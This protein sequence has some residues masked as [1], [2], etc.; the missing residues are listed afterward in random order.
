MKALVDEGYKVTTGVLNELDTDYETAELLD[1]PTVSESPF[2]PIT[3]QKKRQN[4]ELTN[5]AAIIVVTS[6]PF[7][8]GNVSNLEAALDAVKKGTKTYVIDE[9]PIVDRDFTNGKAS[10]IFEELRSHG[11][12][13]IKRPIE[14]PTLVNAT[15]DRLKLEDAENAAIPGHKK[16]LEKPATQTNVK[17]EQ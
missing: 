15:H 11:A 8:L 6:V 13:F 1:V 7:G 16:L 4:L 14:L 12:I 9:I 17:D 3:E 10:A 5:Q 2:S